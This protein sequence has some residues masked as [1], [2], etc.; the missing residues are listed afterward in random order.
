LVYYPRRNGPNEFH[1]V[2]TL[3]NWSVIDELHKI[4]VPTLLINGRYDEA[5]DEV[6]WPFF[7]HIAKV[8]W[9]QFSE[10]SH[11]PQWEERERYMEVVGEFLANA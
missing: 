3:K 1:I 11:L 8:K 10:S 9:I 2:G 5:Q 4:T 6:V 7:V